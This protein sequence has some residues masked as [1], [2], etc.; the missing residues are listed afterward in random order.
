M[1]LWS[2]TNCWTRLYLGVHFPGD[3][4]TGLCWG[5]ICGTAVYFLLYRRV[6]KVEKARYLFNDINIPI[7]VLVYTLLFALLKSTLA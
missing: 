6:Y 4:L 2:L 7:G 5:F 1:V 3:I